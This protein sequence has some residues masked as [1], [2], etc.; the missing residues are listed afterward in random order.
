[1]SV[2]ARTISRCVVHCASGDLAGSAAGC[3]WWQTDK[4]ISRSTTSL[5][6]PPL[7]IVNL[8]GRNSAA[9]V[10]IRNRVKIVRSL[11]F[12]GEH[13]EKDV[14]GLL[15]RLILGAVESRLVLRGRPVQQLH[16]NYP[17]GGGCFVATFLKPPSSTGTEWAALGGQNDRCR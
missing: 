13:G 8:V 11:K 14:T 1:M 7:G 16:L 9:A 17:N 2:K 3:G 4:R 6:A 12:T 15:T 5:G 10:V